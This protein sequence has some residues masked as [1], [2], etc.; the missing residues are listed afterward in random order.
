V[1]SAVDVGHLQKGHAISFADLDN[2]GDQDVFEEMGGAV[3]SDRAFSALYENPG[4]AH[5][6]LSLELEGVRSN[7]SAIG[8]RLKV[9]AETDGGPRALHRTVGS[10]GSF[11][12]SP[13]RA[14]IGLGSARRIRSV[15]VYWPATGRTQSFEGFSLDRRYR[16]RED[17]AEAQAIAR[18]S[19]RL[20]QSR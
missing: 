3:L 10:G 15:E 4:N 17:S 8:A 11:G 14:E 6:W 20:A 2:D 7:R 1:T 5:H 13:L 18:P 16:I 12:A 9:V 19:F